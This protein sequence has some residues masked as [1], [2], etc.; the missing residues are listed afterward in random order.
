MQTEWTTHTPEPQ[1]PHLLRES[2]Q[3][4]PKVASAQAKFCQL[5]IKQLPA[6]QQFQGTGGNE[7]QISRAYL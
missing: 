5:E 4:F 7:I 1:L 6:L 3:K 2:T